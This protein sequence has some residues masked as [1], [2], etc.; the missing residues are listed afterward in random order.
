METRDGARRVAGVGAGP[1]LEYSNLLDRL[2]VSSFVLL[3]CATLALACRST[4]PRL[5]YAQLESDAMQRPM[6]YGYYLPPGQTEASLPAGLPL[7]VFL[8][9][10]G[11]EPE[12]LDEHGVG[13][14]FDQAIEAGRLPPFVMIVPQGDLGFWTNWY[15]GSRRYEDWILDELLPRAQARFRTTSCPRGCHVMGISMGGFGAIR[16]VLHEPGLFASVTSISGPVFDTDAMVSFGE[17]FWAR[18]FMRVE[19]IFGPVDDLAR[20]AR[21]DVYQVWRRPSD[22]NG[23]RLALAWGDEER[24]GIAESNERFSRHLTER[25]I[26]HARDVYAGGHDWRSWKPVFVRGLERV[27]SNTV[28]GSVARPLSR[29]SGAD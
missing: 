23:T 18:T 22:L 25:G 14:V 7:V 20:L 10:G 1:R 9:G 27:L 24:G 16:F 13:A 21:E 15:D 11:D 17:N 26:P 4:A 5:D 19:D 2:H 8:H 28:T 12:T 6:D 29:E 3:I